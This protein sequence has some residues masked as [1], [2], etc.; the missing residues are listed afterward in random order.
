MP[1]AHTCLLIHTHLKT[2]AHADGIKYAQ[3]YSHVHIVYVHTTHT[4][5]H[6][7]TQTNTWRH[8][9]THIPA[10]TTRTH[11]RTH[12][13]THAC[14]THTHNIHMHKRTCTHN[15]MRTHREGSPTHGRWVGW[16][17]GPPSPAAAQW[18]R[19]PVP[20][21]QRETGGPS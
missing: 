21:L 11:T 9:R 17:Q 5:T 4:H 6:A 1:A 12:A 7:R 10:C 3:A 14:H 19:P 2:N 15:P 18:P 8:A 13:H 16:T 20:Q